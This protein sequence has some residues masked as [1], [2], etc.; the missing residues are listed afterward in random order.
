MNVA[1]PPG[2][3][4]IFELP[5]RLKRLAAV[6]LEPSS[7]WIVILPALFALT[8]TIIRPSA[9][10]VIPVMVAFALEAVVIIKYVLVAPRFQSLVVPDESAVGAFEEYAVPVKV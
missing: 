3:I 8:S 6:E 4:M 10:P 2:A 1:V 5:G 9:P 7:C